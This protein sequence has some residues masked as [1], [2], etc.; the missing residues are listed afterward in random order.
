MCINHW[1]MAFCIVLLIITGFYIGRPLTITGGETWKKFF[2]ANVRFVHILFGLIL[3]SLFV[4]RLYLAFFSRFHADWKDFFAWLDFKNAYKQIKFYTLIS[5]QL[6]EK[7]G[8]YGKLYY[9][10]HSL[11]Y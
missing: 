10:L 8:L 6:P 2:M 5:T 7:T 11:S 1:A 9:F 4:W 3:T